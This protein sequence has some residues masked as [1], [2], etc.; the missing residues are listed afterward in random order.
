[1][2][3]LEGAVEIGDILQHLHANDR[4]KLP[5]PIGRRHRVRVLAFHPPQRGAA[6]P[7]C[8][9]LVRANVD[10]TDAPGG[11]HTLCRLIGI[12]AATTADI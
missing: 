5:L 3:R 9:D 12:E 7:R 2:E 4:I 6:C 10:G 8:R 11:S 1:M